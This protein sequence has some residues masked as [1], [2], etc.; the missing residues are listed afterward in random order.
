MITRAAITRD[1]RRRTS[2]VRAQGAAAFALL[3]GCGLLA[4]CGFGVKYPTFQDVAYRIE[5]DA[6]SP[7]GGASVR[8][9]IYRDGPRMRV[10]TTPAGGSTAAIVFNEATDAAYLLSEPTAIPAQQPQVAQT[11]PPRT[12]TTTTP[13]PPAAAPAPV[14]STGVAVRVADD[15]A[16]RPME[17]PW[18]ALA[19]EDVQRVGDCLVAGENG[20][21]WRPKSNVQLVRTAC[22][23]DDGIVLRVRENERVIFQAT[24]LQRGAQPAR[25]FGVPSN[26]QVID[27]EAMARQVGETLEQL[28]SVTGKAKAPVAQPAQPATRTTAP[29]AP[30]NPG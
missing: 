26:Y 23:T 19:A 18:A 30:A 16:P 11:T 24:N 1:S 17:A 9:V 15:H 28:D 5:G 25:L 2:G 29:A 13:E 14:V 8:T 3:V 4:G 6:A 10:E 20:R 27:P 12:V 7:D 22:I 21:E